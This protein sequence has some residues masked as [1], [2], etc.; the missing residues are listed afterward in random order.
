MADLR[1]KEQEALF[2]H[3]MKALWSRLLIVGTGEVPDGAFPSLAVGA[4]ELLF[5]DAWSARREVPLEAAEQLDEV[6]AR[7]PAYKREFDRAL[8]AVT[9]PR[10]VDRALAITGG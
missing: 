10:A 1:G 9:G 7:T 8:A 3:A 6:L 2:T 4:T 5:E